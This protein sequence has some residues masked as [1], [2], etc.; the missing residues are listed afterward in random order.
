MTFSDGF[1]FQIGRMFA[2][3]AVS[4]GILF[5]IGFIFLIVFF[6]AN[7]KQRRKKL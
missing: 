6:I 4:F 7:R 5:A 3:L 1:M 2:E